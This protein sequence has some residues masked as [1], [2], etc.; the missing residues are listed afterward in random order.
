L[1]KQVESLEVKAFTVNAH[2][3]YFFRFFH[4]HK[5]MLLQ[6]RAA[7]AKRINLPKISELSKW[8]YPKWTSVQEVNWFANAK[9]PLGSQKGAFR[10][11]IKAGY[12]LMK[13]RGGWRIFIITV[14]LLKNYDKQ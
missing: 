14:M 7:N 10:L 12:S 3:V 8:Q 5:S 4:A 1:Y 11:A 6:G 2:I 9:Q 13:N